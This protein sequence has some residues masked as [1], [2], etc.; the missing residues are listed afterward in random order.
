MGE[1]EDFLQTRINAMK[2]KDNLDIPYYSA[3][4]FEQRLK[5]VGEFLCNDISLQLSAC[6]SMFASSSS[7][8]LLSASLSSFLE[9]TLLFSTSHFLLFSSLLESRGLQKGTQGLME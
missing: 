6:L 3:L 1:T 8:L 7:A 9:S 5:L 4:G 2:E